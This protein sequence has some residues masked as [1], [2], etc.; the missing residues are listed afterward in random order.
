MARSEIAINLGALRRNVRVLLR[1]LDGAE[2][3]A[4]VK[5]NGYGHGATDIAAAALASG[6]RALCVATVAEGL[7]LR[8]ELP[9]ARIVVM[10]PTSANR[11]VAAARDAALEL[12]VADEIPEGVA[13]H[14]KLDTGMGRWGVSEL[15]A[16]EREVVGVM[17][18]LA[19]ADTDP[20]FAR[21]Q[22]ERFRAATDPLS[23]LTRHVANSAAAL[24]LPESRFDAVRCGIALYGL[25]PFGTDPGEDGLEPVLSWTSEI[26]QSKLLHTGES[27]GYGRRFVAE[28]D[29]WIGIMPLG[30]ADGFS[31]DL[32]GTEVRVAGE[33]RRV[34]G[35][36]S[37]DATAVELDRELPPGTP[38]TIVG[39]GMPLEEH[40]RVANTITYELA[41]RINASPTRA[42][43]VVTDS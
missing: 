35:A 4:V 33:R 11:E 7:A 1:A 17:T 10:G 12:V 38:V 34:I 20:D 27:T 16:P 30:Y 13:V 28:H 6:A 36:V 23:H 18:H 9:A 32:T 19:T 41:S 14:V 40:A 37:M 43:R 21:L 5:A 2:L 25:S 39:H 29:T 42:R 22:I 26:A 31:R 15:P 8:P 3:W 24:R